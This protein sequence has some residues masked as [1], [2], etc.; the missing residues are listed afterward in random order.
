[1]RKLLLIGAVALTGCANMTPEQQDQFRQNFMMGLGAGAAVRQPVYYQA[2]PPP[3]PVTTVC[4]RGF[5]GTVV[6]DT[7]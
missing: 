2:P 7:Q 4:R 5:N 3:M 6:C 1:M